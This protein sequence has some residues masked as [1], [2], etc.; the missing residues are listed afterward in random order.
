M[1]EAIELCV[2]WERALLKQRITQQIRNRQACGLSPYL[3][4]I[5]TSGILDYT[6]VG[7]RHLLLV[8]KITIPELLFSVE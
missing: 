4:N 7:S 3:F 1:Y 6:K 5:V 2:K 8:G